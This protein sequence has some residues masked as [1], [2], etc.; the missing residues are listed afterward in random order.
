MSKIFQTSKK[1]ATYMAGKVSLIHK[2][3]PWLLPVLIIIFFLL[4]SLEEVI[5]D[6]MEGD[7]HGIDTKILESLRNP[8][9]I[10][11]P[12]GP[13]WLQEVMRDFS[14]L[15]GI[16][17]LTML[18]LVAIFYLFVNKKN[19]K[20]WFLLL[21]VGSGTLL[22]NI[23]KAGFDRPRPDLVAHETYTYTASFPSGHSMMAAVVYLT[24]GT[25]LAENEK[26]ER[27][28][29]FIMAVAILMTLLVGISRVYLGA[30]WASDVLAGWLAG[31]A[32]ALLFWL[33]ERYFLYRQESQKARA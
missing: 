4:A 3:Q 18:T 21:A 24:L 17:I 7:T 25:I 29:I 12:I 32:W 33:V 14:A 19:F 8:A 6:V 26:N 22:T 30:H 27:I 20:A 16:A 2:L 1:G 15:G 11:D 31:S 5:D 28:K 9:D 10:S 23:L 13:H